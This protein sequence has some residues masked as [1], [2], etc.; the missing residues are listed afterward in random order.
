MVYDLFDSESDYVIDREPILEQTTAYLRLVEEKKIWSGALEK[1]KHVELSS[2]LRKLHPALL[3]E[4]EVKE[5]VYKHNSLPG[6]TAFG[7]SSGVVN[8]AYRCGKC[9]IIFAGRPNI[10]LSDSDPNSIEYDCGVCKNT[11]YTEDV[12]SRT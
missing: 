5:T 6:F 3:E 1:P 9:T 7:I 2:G 10:H 4:I 12:D 8:L 11:M